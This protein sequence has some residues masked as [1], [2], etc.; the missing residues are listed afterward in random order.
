MAAGARSDLLAGWEQPDSGTSAWP[1]GSPT[2]P[3]WQ[4]VAVIPQALALLDELTVAENI[5]LPIR[6]AHQSR[7]S[8]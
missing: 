8:R 4:D 5:T 7:Q 3:S 2:R 1:D 6:A